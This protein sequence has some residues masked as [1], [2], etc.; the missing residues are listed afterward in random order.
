M[1]D[2]PLREWAA[3]HDV[4]LPPTPGLPNTARRVHLLGAEYGTTI[5]GGNP[6]GSWLTIDPNGVTCPRCLATLPATSDTPGSEEGT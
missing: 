3:E 6:A 2:D 1:A 4:I 5:C